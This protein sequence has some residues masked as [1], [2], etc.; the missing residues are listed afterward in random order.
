MHRHLIALVWLAATTLTASAQIYTDNA[1][2]V[3]IYE[4]DTIPVIHMR[5]VYIYSPP[6]FKNRRTEKEYWRNVRDIKK[7]LPLAQEIRGIIIETYEYMQTLPDDKARERH[8]KKV[9]KDLMSTYTP[10]MKQLTLR[11]GKM[12]IKLV[13]RECNQTGYDLIVVFR[14]KFRAT[15]YQAFAALFGASLKNGYDPEGADA[16]LEEIIWLVENDIL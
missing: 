2:P 15:F 9:E 5:D 4:G 1:L 3:D 10:R 11:Q 13:D 12:L 7:T 6:K 8:M 14:G 16:E